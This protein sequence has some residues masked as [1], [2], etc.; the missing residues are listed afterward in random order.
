MSYEVNSLDPVPE[1]TEI[2]MEGGEDIETDVESGKTLDET[3]SFLRRKLRGDVQNSNPAREFYK[4]GAARYFFAAM[5]NLLPWIVNLILAIIVVVLAFKLEA[6]TAMSKS[7]IPTDVI[8][9]EWTNLSVE[10]LWGEPC[11]L[12]LV[13]NISAL[14]DEAV[15][16]RIETTYAS[17]DFPDS[18]YQGWP[19]AH[20]DKLWNK[21]EG[22]FNVCHV[23]SRG[24]F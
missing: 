12:T 9:S 16:Y 6:K 19:D 23:L 11:Q 15:E 14:A 8:Y 24:L 21:Y 22:K 1:E 2:E 3:L 13:P 10:S 18:D 17:E 20:K 4:K 5:C 7:Q